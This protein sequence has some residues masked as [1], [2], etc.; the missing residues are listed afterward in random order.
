MVGAVGW[1]I[2]PLAHD[3]DI[4]GGHILD[5]LAW[6]L[7]LLVA[8]MPVARGGSLLGRPVNPTSKIR[9]AEA[10]VL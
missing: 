1:L 6:S 8:V 10:E 9:C 3:H 4:S 7:S 5:R 2:V